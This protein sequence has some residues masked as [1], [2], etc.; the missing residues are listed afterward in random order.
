MF[1]NMVL[2]E[3]SK[4]LKRLMFWVQ[5]LLLA[6]GALFFLTILYLVAKQGGATP[7]ETPPIEMALWPQAP[8]N[9]MGLAET[10]RM[11]GL[12]MVILVGAFTAQEYS[13]RTVH[14]SLSQGLP[15]ASFLLA[16]FVALL[17]PALLF[18]I[19]PLLAGTLLSALFTYLEL[20]TLNGGEIQVGRLLLNLLLTSYSLLPYAALAFFLAVVSRSTVVAVGGGLAYLL[21]F[22]QILLFLLSLLGERGR[23]LITYVPFVLVQSLLPDQPPGVLA[24][25]MLPPTEAAFWL[26]LL[27]VGLL[28]LTVIAFQRQDLTG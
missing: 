23:A 3:E 4:L 13:W 1:W 7:Q 20:G 8:F 11:G 14:L 28:S 9:A 27:V 19:T 17:L 26:G 16:K 6:A 10:T 21:L 25:G 2:I 15:R 5:L 18:V 22:E 12:M 24:P